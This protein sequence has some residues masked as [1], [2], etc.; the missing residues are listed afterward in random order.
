MPLH[1]P[2]EPE[3]VLLGAAVL[4][5]TAGGAHGSVAEAMAAMSA[6][7]GAVRPTA[8]AAVVRYHEKKYTV[9]LRMSDDQRAYREMM[10][11]Q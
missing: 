2:R 6:I 10:A 7:E 5:A 1:L 11:S 3:A 8:D 4:G 9:F